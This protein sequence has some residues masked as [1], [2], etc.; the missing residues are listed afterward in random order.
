M[1]S[2]QPCPGPAGATDMHHIPTLTATGLLKPSCP[3]YTETTF[4]RLGEIAISSNSQEQRKSNK[5]G[6]QKN[7]PQMKEQGKSPGKTT[8]NE[9]EKSN[10]TD[11]EFKEMVIRMLNKLESIIEEL[12]RAL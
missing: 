3:V 11:R 6:R 2:E 9:M 8:T 4:S 10:L 1:H 12:E 5:M 7:M